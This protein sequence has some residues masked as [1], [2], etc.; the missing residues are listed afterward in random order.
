MSTGTGN[1]LLGC[2][3]A[4]DLLVPPEMG[5]ST[6]DFRNRSFDEWCLAVVV[7]IGILQYSRAVHGGGATRTAGS[8]VQPAEAKA[9]GP[10]SRVLG[11][12]ESKALL[13]AA[14]I[15]TIETVHAVTAAEAVRE[16]NRIG[17]P[18]VLKVSA[19]EI[20]HKSDHGGVLLN[21]ADAEAVKRGFE[22]LEEVALRASATF[23]GVTVQ[24]MAKA[25]VEVIIGGHKDPQFGPVIA[26]G[27]GGVFV[28][29]LRDIALRVAPLSAKDASAMLEE[30]KGQALLDGLRGRPPCDRAAI[31]G[32][33]CRLSNL[34]LARPDIMSIDANPA[35]VYPNG[36]SVADARIVLG[37]SEA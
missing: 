34:M 22:S 26:F 10:V 35:F 5:F 33:L 6:L 20:T 37:S 14:G 9:D 29:V 21:V 4:N 2:I 23:Q 31:T 12:A 27:L 7:A 1:L 28:E 8:P 11:E 18:V 15:P 25:G 32:A 24:P 16:A 3:S 17:Y 19:A 36:L 13:A 30:V